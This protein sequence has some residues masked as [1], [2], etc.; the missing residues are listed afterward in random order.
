[1]FA[2]PITCLIQSLYFNSQFS[3]FNLNL[4][5]LGLV[6]WIPLFL[7]FF[8]FK[9]YLE[10]LEQ[11]L[12]AGK[13]LIAGTVPVIVSCFGQYWFGWY[14]PLETLNGLIIW[15]QRPMGFPNYDGMTGLFNNPNYT[16]AW[17]C[18]ILPI[19]IV[20]A[21]KKRENFIKK[22]ISKIFVILFFVSILL[23]LSRNA[24]LGMILSIPL[25]FKK[26][27][28]IF[29]ISLI[30]ILML[31][32]FFYKREIIPINLPEFNEKFFF[33]NALS[34]FSFKNIPGRDT[35]LN[36]WFNTLSFIMERP[37]TGW[38]SNSLPILYENRIGTYIGHPHNIFLELAYSYGIP[39]ALSISFP[40]I[41]IFIKSFRK[42]ILN[43]EF[44]NLFDRGWFCSFAICLLLQMNDLTYFD[45]RISLSFWIFLSGLSN[46][47]K[48]LAKNKSKKLNI[49]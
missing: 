6:N 27:G 43:N 33:N 36:I 1:M 34:E 13:I 25:I 12:L 22:Y 30:F 35:R 18:S 16:G 5:W 4:L 24:W 37:F 47:I 42:L 41:D 11:R 49:Y 9:K 21:F 17:F 31:F 15:Y 32:Y 8:G 14:G 23:T 2:M 39:L 40:I 7:C 28:I 26:K 44:S 10:T 19:S 48:D 46:I 38:G 45:A 3:N 20:L 29:L